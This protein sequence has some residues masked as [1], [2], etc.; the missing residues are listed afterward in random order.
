MNTPTASSR[1]TQH[2]LFSLIGFLALASG[3]AANPRPIEPTPVTASALAVH[4]SRDGRPKDLVSRDAAEWMTAPSKAKELEETA[5]V[6]T[7]AACPG[8]G[9]RVLLIGDSLAAG[10]GPHMARRARTC[11]TA[12]FHHGVVG[13]HVTEW[14]QDS[15]LLPELGRAEP[16]VVIVSLGGNDFVR[17]DAA[18]VS[19]GVR[20]FVEKVRASGARLLWISPPT[21]PFRDKIGVR[22]LWQ[23]EL[24]GEM[25]IDWYPTETLEIPRVA[26]R[27]HPTIPGYDDLGQKLWAWTSAVTR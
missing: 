3:C 14:A 2:A 7:D 25:N 23:D 22:Q 6:P 15:W 27:V 17:S 19:R 21:M 9:A 11:G 12:F 18:N 16:S 8:A 5:A 10:L 13:S 20:R 24:A 26:D 1:R 4:A